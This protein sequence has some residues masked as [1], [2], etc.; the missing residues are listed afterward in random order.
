MPGGLAAERVKAAVKHFGKLVE[1][2]AYGDVK[3]GSI[4]KK[5]IGLRSAGGS[6]LP[7]SF[8]VLFIR[9]GWEYFSGVC[10]I[11]TPHNAKKQVADMR[12]IGQYIQKQI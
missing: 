1:L 3:M 2:N 6:V 8:C 5:Q 11:D 7:Y 10:L 12:I 4:A 9:Y